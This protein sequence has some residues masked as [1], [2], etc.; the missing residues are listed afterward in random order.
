MENLV[1]LHS[2]ILPGLDDGPDDLS[3]SL[4]MLRNLEKLGF[5]HVFA[6]PHQRLYSWEGLSAER[7]EREVREV[8]DAAR[9]EGMDI[10]LLPGMEYD[11]DETLPD[12]VSQRPGGARHMLVDVGFWGI[13]RDLGGLLEELLEMGIDVLLVHPERNRDLCRWLRKVDGR[14]ASAV[15]V[16][17]NL[18]SLS[19]MYGPKVQRYARD[20][21]AADLYW[22]MASDMHSEEQVPWIRHGIEELVSR[23]GGTLAEQLL[24]TNPM[25]I[26]TAMEVDL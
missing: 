12:R 19:G 18:G 13:P 5:E 20:L 7:V 11:L 14:L 24:A 16:V 4:G 2:H 26:V 1:D 25:N 3:G 8:S 10:N 6:T 17:G 21:L 15:R 22:A 9:Q 23:K